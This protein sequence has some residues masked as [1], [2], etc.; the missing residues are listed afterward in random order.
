VSLRLWLLCLLGLVAAL[1]APARAGSLDLAGRFCFAVTDTADGRAGSF[2]CEGAPEAYQDRRLWLRAD[3]GGF[4]AGDGA[5]V[6]VHQSRFNRLAVRFAYADGAVLERSVRAGAYGAH[7]RVGGNLV[8]EAPPRPARLATVTLVFDRLASASLVRARALRPDVQGRDAA[9]GAALVGGA[10]ALLFLSTVYN[11]ALAVGVRRAFV[12]WHAAWVASV[13]VWSLLWSQLA[14][15]AVPAVAGTWASRLATLLAC[16]AIA[17][18]T[19]SAVTAL[20]PG[21]LPRRARRALHA[22]A[23]VNAIVALPVVFGPTEWLRVTGPVLS[24]SSL[25]AVAG[26]V[27]AIAWAW[28]RGSRSAR[29]FALTWSLPMAVLALTDLVDL[30]SGLFG[31]GP[32]F[33]VLLASAAQT[34]WLSLV[35]TLRLAKLKTERDAARAAQAEL[36]ELAIR[37]PLTGL[38]NR[39]GFVARAQ[40]ALDADRGRAR[41]GLLV[42]D[43]DRFKS[44]NDRYGHDAGDRALNAVAALLQRFAD[45]DLFVGRLGGEEFGIGI[46]GA[47]PALLAELAERV[48]A[49]IAAARLDDVEPGLGLTASIGL[50]FGQ[51]GEGFDAVYRRADQALY[52]AKRA[53]R[54]RVSAWEGE[55]IAAGAASAA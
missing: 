2:A 12:G 17:C 11:A 54:D 16:F 29:D 33:A 21:T 51:P 39:R 49:A 28:R 18:A 27:A 37:D 15:L 25:A 8:F 30:G 35:T 3:I 10:T 55:A 9:V 5:S 41:F 4:D 47:P 34:V 13:L 22:V 45:D 46:D 38:L 24:L 19:L 52:A 42:V 31:G 6:V 36:R 7:W 40:R 53:G 43:V 50:A 14:L 26:V 32:Q 48:R 44:I 23:A 20:E 1:A